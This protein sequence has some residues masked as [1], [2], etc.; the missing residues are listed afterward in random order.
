MILSYSVIAWLDSIQHLI[1][2]FILQIPSLAAKVAR[3]R[4]Q[5]SER[6]SKRMCSFVC[7]GDHAGLLNRLRAGDAGLGNRPQNIH[8]ST[9]KW[10]PLC[11]EKGLVN[12]LSEHHVVI[13]CQA[14]AYE[15]S[16][17]GLQA[18]MTGKVRSS[19]ATLSGILGGDNASK[20]VLLEQADKITLI[21]DHLL[22]LTGSL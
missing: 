15:R 21:L 3:S 5:T 13:F 19:T 1:A 6:Q 14:V 11:L 16:A 2:H 4:V 17:T 20:E 10:C 12:N 8:G 18:L 22:F 9:T 7:V